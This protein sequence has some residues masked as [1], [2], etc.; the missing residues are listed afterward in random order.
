[1]THQKPGDGTT[2]GK[3]DTGGL[4]TS[5]SQAGSQKRMPQNP[6]APGRINN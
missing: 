4:G 6:G 1:M 5:T 3:K 2:P